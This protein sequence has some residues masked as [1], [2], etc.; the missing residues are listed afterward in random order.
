MLVKEHGSCRAPVW[1][2]SSHLISQTTEEEGCHYLGLCLLWWTLLWE[3][4]FSIFL[5][6]STWLEASQLEWPFKWWDALTNHCKQN[7]TVF[8]WS[9]GLCSLKLNSKWAL[10]NLNLSQCMMAFIITG[11]VILAYCSQVSKYL[12]KVKKILNYMFYSGKAWKH[13]IVK[14]L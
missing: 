14:S 12:S 1:T 2:P 11:L 5:L 9:R 10:F 4:D 3:P 6:L 13:L 7:H 8:T